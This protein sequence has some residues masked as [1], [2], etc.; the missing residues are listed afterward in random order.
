MMTSIFLLL[1]LAGGSFLNVV[2]FRLNKKKPF[3]KGRS[4]C[5]HCQSKIVWYDNIPLLSFLLLGGR[6][7]QCQK[8]ISWQYP[9]VELATAII[10][11][12]LYLS[13]GLSIKFFIYLILS[14][15]LIIIF[16]YDLKYYLILDKVVGPAMVIAFLANLYLGLGF[17]NLIL[18]ALIGSSFF[19]LQFY[20]SQGKWVG[21]GDIRLGALMGLML[22][23]KILL[24]ALFLAYLIGAGF[25]LILIAL[26]KKKMSSQIPFGPFLVA[27]TFISLVYGPSLLRWYLNLIYYY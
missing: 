26:N 1:G 8:S 14:C 12:W 21:G 4:F 11:V 20:L 3:L 6:C 15:F 10:F 27:A 5:P 9:L 16:V 18:G 13:F 7:R 17:W 25:G 2:I 22:G 23:W 24:V 19:A